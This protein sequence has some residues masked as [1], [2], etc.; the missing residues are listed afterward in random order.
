MRKNPGGKKNIFSQGLRRPDE[1][2]DGDRRRHP[3]GRPLGRG[4]VSADAQVGRG[5][6]QGLPS[7]NF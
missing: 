6:T 1:G 5:E 2:R 7:E 3:G 4:D